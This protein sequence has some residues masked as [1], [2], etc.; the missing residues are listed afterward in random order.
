VR[1][2]VAVLVS[3]AGLVGPGVIVTPVPTASGATRTFAH[4]MRPG[5]P[6]R[7][8]VEKLAPL[9]RASPGALT[10]AAHVIERRLGGLGVPGS[11]VAVKGHD[12]FVSVPWVANYAGVL[13]A[14][15]QRAEMFIRPVVCE[16]GPFIAPAKAKAKRRLCA[17]SPPV[18]P[19]PTRS[20]G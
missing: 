2:L 7:L 8:L 11:N 13:K 14:V 18:P 4:Q 5:Q 3:V 17:P 1:K 20:A 15:A 9:R 16:I 19:W 6:M 12:I 10:A